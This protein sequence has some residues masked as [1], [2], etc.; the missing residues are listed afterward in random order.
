MSSDNEASQRGPMTGKYI[1]VYSH[2]NLMRNKNCQNTRIFVKFN[3]SKGA[4]TND[5][6][7]T[8]CNICMIPP[9]VTGLDMIHWV[10]MYGN[11]SVT[12]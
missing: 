4:F 8:I 1:F 11:N 3:F 9:N 7:L 10:C 2:V 6:T 5:V 12:C